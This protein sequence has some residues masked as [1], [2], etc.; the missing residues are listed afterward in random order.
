MNRKLLGL[1]LALAAMP[2]IVSGCC[3]TCR[4]SSYL[5]SAPPVAAP[6]V[7]PTCEGPLP[8]RLNGA[9]V[10]APPGAFPSPANPG[11][12]S[13]T[14]P[15]EPPGLSGAQPMPSA[16]STPPAYAQQPPSTPGGVRLSPPVA[17]VPGPS[18]SSANPPSSAPSVQLYPPQPKEPAQTK[19]PPPAP[20]SPPER[21]PPANEPTEPPVRDVIPQFELAKPK[22][23]NGD[24]PFADGYQ[25]LKDHGYRTVLHIHEPGEDEKEARQ[26]VERAGLTYLSLAVSPATLKESFEKFKRLVQGENNLPLFVYD[27]D[28]SLAGGLWYLYYR[29]VDNLSA[30][31]AEAAAA[32]LGFSTTQE[33]DRNTWLAIQKL[34]ADRKRE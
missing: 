32:G 11:P 16:P 2:L 33:K 22:V 8:P 20:P 6:S 25:W 30:D 27:R 28:G 26:D 19:E 17:S 21:M 31:K 15:Y 18:G 34:L 10:P 24:R 9:P 4:T 29:L 3:S 23:A 13:A 5:S 12:L 14:T 7:C 1:A